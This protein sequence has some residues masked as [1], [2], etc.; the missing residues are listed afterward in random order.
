MRR[1]LRGIKRREI[2]LDFD[3]YRVDIPLRNHPEHY[4]SVVD[5]APE[6][7]EQ[8]I[9]FIH[10]LGGCVET[11]EYQMNAFADQ[12][13]IVTPDL[14]GH[15]QSSAPHTQYTM[16][17]MIEDLDTVV[18]ALALPEQF[19]L[20]GHSFGGAICI[21]YANIYPER[22]S[23]L[24]LIAAAG[25]Y[26][27]PRAIN[28]L[29][30]IPNLFYRLWWDYR[31]RWNAELH[32]MKRMLSN[33][34]RKWQGWPLLRNLTMPTLVI[35]GQRD[36][37]F[38]RAVFDD[39]AKMIPNAE[40][41]DVG[42]AKHKVQLERHQA[43]NRVLGRF[44]DEN[45]RQTWREQDALNEIVGRRPWIR[46]YSAGTPSTVPMPK[47]PVDRFLESAANW[48]PKRTAIIFYGNRISYD[49][50]NQRVNRFARG[51]LQA[52][53]AKGDRVTLVLPNVPQFII[54]YYGT[55]R[56]G[57]VIVLPNPDAESEEIASQVRQTDSRFFVTL[58]DY[59][60]LATTVK[61]ETNV[62][63]IIFADIRAVMANS[64]YD[65]LSSRWKTPEK[66]DSEA[67]NSV[68]TGMARFYAEDSSAVQQN[69][70][71]TD[72]ATIIY[73]SGTTDSP[74][75]VSLTHANLVANTV[76]TRH[77]IPDMHYGE[78]IFL[79]VLPLLHSYG[80]TTAMNIPIAIAATI[81]LMPVFEL[82]EVL[83]HIKRYKPTIFPGVPS[84]YTA[85][86]HAPNVRRYGLSSI[87][88]CLSG[89]A[90]LPIEV[91]E[92]FE[93]LTHGRL[94]E[95]YGLTEASPTT[96]ANP[97]Y[98]LRKVGSIGVPI[99]NTDARIVDLITGEE[100]ELGQVGEL[101]ISGPQVMEGYWAVDEAE[102]ESCLKDGWLYTGD[103]AVMDADGYFQIISRKRDTIMAG[104]YSVYPRDVEEVLY[105]NS[106]VLEA[107]VV[108]VAFPE[109]NTQRIKAFVVP[110]PGTT[111]SK[112]ELMALCR[113]RL[114]D[115][116]VPW[117][118]EF[119]ESLPKSFV[120]KVLRRMLVEE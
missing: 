70:A 116:A 33:N 63:Q 9:M 72:R 29:L 102:Q 80:M 27:L 118:I 75:G 50:L 39:V 101:I 119:R 36:T 47:Q 25:E 60:P 15:G 64:E 37:Y 100:V 53:L 42:A 20:V 57:G 84:M 8:T 117:D 114:D 45:T 111:L 81:V 19:V 112:E 99:P 12:F 71:L 16:D 44:L 31:P 6:G 55:L 104:K 78:E 17:E 21:E 65:T 93:K 11:W 22:V 97:L 10:G 58:G 23:K 82:D 61:A 85:I 2:K 96:H 35:T 73:T 54:A 59:L 94:V 7:V 88:A 76:Q 115:Y 52:G 26:P 46:H 89:A 34:L 108:G 107:A 74:K 32:V 38:P 109:A 41:H 40:E 113:R 13:R 120:G 103:L 83:A 24:V 4:L 87:K 1:K 77:W 86:N 91:Q 98:G 48:L 66:I 90:P 106:K 79:S 68:G 69:I 43:V 30:R 5:L 14:R 62:E 56:A 105:E 92:A 28:W 51:L 95:G 67:L 18:K 110:Q 49:D 3:L